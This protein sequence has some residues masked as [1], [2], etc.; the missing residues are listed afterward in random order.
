MILDQCWTD[1]TMLILAHNRCKWFSH[2]LASVFCKTSLSDLYHIWFH[3][4][5]TMLPCNGRHRHPNIIRFTLSTVI[6]LMMNG[7]GL[8]RTNFFN[9]LAIRSIVFGASGRT[10]RIPYFSLIS[11]EVS[12]IDG[13]GRLKSICVYAPT[14]GFNKPAL[15][16]LLFLGA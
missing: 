10:A 9:P 11:C 6:T 14:Y 8:S 16:S 15:T 3:N 7:S 13:H 12:K 5:I 2:I 4:S 1:K